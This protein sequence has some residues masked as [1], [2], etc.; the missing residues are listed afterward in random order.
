MARLG[1]KFLSGY[2]PSATCHN[3]VVRGA[4]IGVWDRILEPISEAYD[5]DF[6]MI[7]SSSCEA[8]TF[9]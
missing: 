1:P 5:G 7:G 6:Q 2:G 3:R 8:S 9:A 4:K